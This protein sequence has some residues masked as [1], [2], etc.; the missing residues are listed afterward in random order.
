MLVT[1]LISSGKWKYVPTGSGHVI[2]V[3]D[4]DPTDI[5]TDN[6]LGIVIE[7]DHFCVLNV[8]RNHMET[9]NKRLT[10]Q[11]IDRIVVDTINARLKCDDGF[12]YEIIG[13]HASY[14]ISTISYKNDILKIH[15]IQVWPPIPPPPIY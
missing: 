2:I 4:I 6:V 5:I 3:E 8:I 15:N 10:I 1:E 11:Q 12:L 7:N 9:L 14:P 13:Q